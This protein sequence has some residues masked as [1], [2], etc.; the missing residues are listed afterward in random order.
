[1]YGDSSFKG[2][3]EDSSE[4]TA[5]PTCSE[6]AMRPAPEWILFREDEWF[7]RSIIHYYSEME[8][9]EEELNFVPCVNVER[10]LQMNDRLKTTEMQRTCRKLNKRKNSN[11]G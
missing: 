8:K 9:A 10:K 2:Y 3:L 7:C 11:I 6:T 5:L 4:I 1:M